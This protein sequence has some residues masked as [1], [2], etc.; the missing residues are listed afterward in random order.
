MQLP[1]WFIYGL[2]FNSL[3]SWW[4]LELVHQ[5]KQLFFN[6]ML[7]ILLSETLYFRCL[8][9][10]LVF[11]LFLCV[12][13]DDRQDKSLGLANTPVYENDSDRVS[14]LSYYELSNL[15]Y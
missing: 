3:V 5:Q 4:L 7:T 15:S 8:T 10:G 1:P 14:R 13:V 2:A 6:C 12:F 11:F 9:F